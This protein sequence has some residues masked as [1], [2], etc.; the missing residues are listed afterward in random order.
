MAVSFLED[1]HGEL[2]TIVRKGDKVEHYS[3]ENVH[4]ACPDVRA[5]VETLL[6]E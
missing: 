5:L 1:D 2:I 4:E 3:R 6:N